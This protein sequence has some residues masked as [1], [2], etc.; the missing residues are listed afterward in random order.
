MR[1]APHARILGS[2]VLVAMAPPLVSG[3]ESPLEE[4]VVTA[5]KR[6]DTSVQD[7]PLSVQ[8]LDGL[9][10][11]DIGAFDFADYARLVPG[12]TMLEQGSGDRRYIVR[13]VNSAG[14]GTVGLYVDEVIITGENAQDG[15]GRQPDVR[16]FD[17]DRVEILKGPQGTTFG[18]SSLA[19][20]IRYITRKPEL[21]MYSGYAQAGVESVDGGD[22]GWQA[23]GALNVPLGEKAAIRAS[24]L[25]RTSAGYIDNLFRDDANSTE[26]KAGR[27]LALIE[28]TDSVRLSFMA[29]RQDMEADGPVYFNLVNYLGAPLSPGDD[30]FQADIVDT[31]FTDEMTLYNAT[32]EMDLSLGQLTAVASRMERD[33]VFSRDSSLVMQRFVG[34]PAYGTGR[35]A[36]IQ[37]KETTLDT[38]ELRLA[39]DNE[40]RIQYLVGLF[41]QSEDRHFRSFI[42]PAPNGQVVY[43]PGY[44]LS[45]AIDTSIDEYAAFGELAF[46]A[47]DRLT[48]TVGA[49][50]Y[51]FDIDE[52]ANNIAVFSGAAGTGLGNPLTSSEDG[53]IFRGN[54]AFAL[55][56]DQLFYLQVAEGFRPGGTNDQVAALIAGVAIPQGYDS[57]S[58]INYEAGYKSTLLDGRLRFNA[59]AYLIKWDDIQ[60]QAE[61]VGP[62]G[63]F[64]YRANGG[65]AEITGAEV[66]VTWFPVDAWQIGVG[67]SLSDAALTT[68]NPLP[69]SGIDGDKV[70]YVPDFTLALSTSYEWNLGALM[71]SLGGDATYVDERNTEYRPNNASYLELDSYTLLNLR[72]GVRSETGNWDAMLNINNVAN[73]DTVVD[74]FRI[75]AGLYPNG[76]II[77]RPRTIAL[78]FTKN[79]Q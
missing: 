3:A 76:Y 42:H 4:I 12:L 46:A 75:V 79:F 31:G 9:A 18:S 35:S 20:T 19:G 55:T 14:A 15:G 73:D 41:S 23:Q 72:A 13:G 45:R 60:L 24:G 56:P 78:T 37:P 77:N 61:A 5:T 52:I 50:Y 66:D 40:N 65:G 44:S 74:V 69:A 2:I 43:T 30:Y 62:G 58:L 29:M 54:A 33:P 59:A 63:R 38:F 21:G 17:I 10:L 64:P 22:L 47:T 49:R 51:N 70:P 36:I 28:P 8:A 34:R 32:L 1:I 39:S 48:L 57:D 16:L 25:Y 71:A 7:I 6:G 68:D 67:A 53:T 11:Q 26:V 27:L